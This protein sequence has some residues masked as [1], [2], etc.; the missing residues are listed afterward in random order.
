M[1]TIML[2]LL[3]TVF[4]YGQG[5]YQPNWVSLDSRP[6]PAWWQDA[7]FGIF[8][9][10]GVYSVPAWGVTSREI[11]KATTDKDIDIYG[12]YAEWYWRRLADSTDKVH[13]YF[14]QHHDS[15]YGENVRYQDFAASFSA[16][17]FRAEEWSELFAASGAKYVVL[18]SKHHEGFALWPS[19]QSWNWNSVDIGPH[20][21]LVGELTRAVKKSGMHM[22]FYYSLYEWYNPQYLHNLPGYVDGHMLPQMK[23][24]VMRYKPDILWGDGEWE[25]TSQEWKTPSFMAWLFNDSPVKESIVINDRWGSD[26]RN[27][28]GGFFTT[29]YEIERLASTSSRPWEECRGI[30]GSFGYNAAERAEDYLTAEAL[31]ALLVKKVSAGGNLLLNVG[32]TADGRIPVIMEDR[33]REVGNWLAINGECIY[34]SRPW[35][36]AKEQPKNKDSSIAFTTKNDALY[37]IA[38]QPN[39]VIQ[40]SGIT[41]SHVTL[42]GHTGKVKTRITT[43]GMEIIAPSGS[44]NTL[45]SSKTWV[46]KIEGKF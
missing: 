26:V 28:H 9:H 36:K 18:T 37:I 27:R 30:G 3:V 23:D 31:I 16:R 8:V 40:I 1:K 39:P 46:Y 6:V 24:L 42:L 14:R 21:D 22:G 33:L 12:K 11:K 35:V 13:Q 29:E 43:N 5:P 44:A 38:L 45:P 4:A 25:H 32:P 2:F 15:I 20:R 41:S 19:A 17:Y 10:W 34:G 7:K